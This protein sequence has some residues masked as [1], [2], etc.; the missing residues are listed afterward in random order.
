MTHKLSG[1]LKFA[2]DDGSTLNYVINA[3]NPISVGPLV[4]EAI[5]QA[6]AS[7]QLEQKNAA[8]PVS[9]PE[10]SPENQAD[11]ESG[12]SEGSV[13]VSHNDDGTIEYTAS[14]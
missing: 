13:T 8:V 2:L 7:Q 5:Q 14:V 6:R 10:I 12:E 3:K 11:W 1:R 4:L 9:A